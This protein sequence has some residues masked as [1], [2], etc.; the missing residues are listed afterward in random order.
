ML[1]RTCDCV[2]H[3]LGQHFPVSKPACDPP[4]AGLVFNWMTGFN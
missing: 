3:A 4:T 1:V 2:T